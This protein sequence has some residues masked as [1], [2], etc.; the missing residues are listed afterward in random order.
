MTPS[1]MT[2]MSSARV[3][4]GNGPGSARVPAYVGDLVAFETSFK[5]GL[6]EVRVNIKIFVEEEIP[7]DE[8]G[9][10]GKMVEEFLQA[11]RDH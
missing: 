7:D 11:A 9:Y 10:A 8:H 4:V 1:A 2:L 3:I 5:R 6:A